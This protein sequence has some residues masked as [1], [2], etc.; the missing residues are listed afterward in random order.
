M[1][2]KKYIIAIT[3]LSLV[4]VALV[5]AVIGIWAAT[6][7]TVTSKLS[8]SYTP[9]TAVVAQ[10]N[11]FYR[12]QGGNKTSIGSTLNY[13]YSTSMNSTKSDAISDQSLTLD[14]TTTWVIYGFSFKNTVNAAANPA[15]AI[16]DVIVTNNS[17]TTGSMEVVVRYTTTAIADASIT[18]TEVGKLTD[19]TGTSLQN[20]ASGSTG[21]MY[22]SI[23]RVAGAKGTFGTSG[24]G[25]T[26]SFKLSAKAAS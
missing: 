14:D 4:I 2:K 3:S 5:G 24:S 23:S 15:A 26:F 6:Q 16:L 8:V 9:S 22:V 12:K 19:Q 1:S 25:S 10:V 13:D 20:L 7:V 17:A 18:P 11:A 21:Y